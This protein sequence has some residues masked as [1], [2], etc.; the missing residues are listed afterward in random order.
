[1]FVGVIFVFFFNF[2]FLAVCVCHSLFC[3]FTHNK[4]SF[5]FFLATLYEKKTSLQTHIVVFGKCFAQRKGEYDQDQVHNA[6]HNDAN[7][8]L[9]LPYQPLGEDPVAALQSKE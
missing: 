1:M 3:C 2:Y 9:A 7:D 4:L 5:F 8:E 6:G